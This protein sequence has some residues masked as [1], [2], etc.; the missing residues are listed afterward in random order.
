MARSLAHERLEHRRN[1]ALQFVHGFVSVLGVAMA[2]EIR[3]VGSSLDGANC[4]FCDAVIINPVDP[5]SLDPWDPTPAC[6]HVF[7]LGHDHGIAYVSQRA[8]EQLAASGVLTIV[9]P[10]L[11]ISLESTE[12][13]QQGDTLELISLNVHGDRAE[14][15]AVY[16]PAPSFEGQYVGVANRLD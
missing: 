15:L 6:E 4:P 13:G 11:G 12:E 8:Q 1:V 2:L 14:I 7:F 9:D 16:A 3:E 5:T 10:A